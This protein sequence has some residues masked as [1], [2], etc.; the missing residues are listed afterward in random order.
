MKNLLRDFR[1]GRSGSLHGR[2]VL[3][4]VL[5]SCPGLNFH[6]AAAQPQAQ[7]PQNSS[8][9][10]EPAGEMAVKDEATTTK[11]AEAAK[12]RVNVR[13][14][15]ARVVVRD[16]KGN[17]VTNLHKEDF[18]LFDNGKPQVISNFDVEHL[19][20]SR[21][22]PTAAPTGTQPVTTTLAGPPALD[23][24][25]P[26]RYVAYLFDDLHLAFESV[27]RVREAAEHRIDRMNPEERIGI[28]STSGLT[29]ADFT[30][31]RTKLRDALKRLGPRPSKGGEI[32]KCPDINLYQADLIINKSDPE[33]EQTAVNEYVNCSAGM[34]TA[35]P[36]N[37]AMNARML[38]R[39]LAMQVL[40][41]EGQ[42]SRTAIGVLKDVVRR[43]STM[44][45]QRTL[46]LVSPGF[47]TPELQY[48]Y[49]EAIDRALRAQ[50]IINSLDARGLY[51]VTPFGDASQRGK[52]DLDVPGQPFT[53]SSHAALD[54]QKASAESEIMATLANATG[55]IFFHN[56]NDM[57]E[58]FRRVGEAPESYYLLGFT[59]TNLKPDGK[60]HNLKV[61][62]K[63]R[64]KYDL[65]VRRGYYAPN[66]ALSDEEEAKREI[67]DEVLSMEELH[68]L[69]VALHT[70]FFKASDDN[71]KL[72]VLARVDV[73]R[74]RY[75]QADDRNQNDL[76][77]VTAVFDRNGN[78]LQA[79]QKVVQMR[80]RSETLQGKLA[81]GITLTT[82]FDVKP[83]RYLVRVVARDTEQKLMSAENGSVEIP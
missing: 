39:G 44:P 12:F 24:T 49:N 82:H 66:H 33:A 9:G 3:L 4:F 2:C 22:Q 26:V 7:P 63:L 29:V 19:D 36:A 35:A 73:K 83:G 20:F 14:V 77:V 48:D 64:E 41:V 46:V 15:L 79:N 30:D 70:Q 59:P 72:T 50:V 56:N 69:P 52:P 13:L 58:G 68:D 34:T 42:D 57:D 54:I 10:Q 18:E 51:V 81:S 23:A 32:N 61:T 21:F 74:L 43:V 47:V 17:A 37:V 28:F 1:L 27:S 65:Q 45:G 71:A 5:L 11:M 60:Y 6:A 25:L 8:A 40:Q 31:D 76:T 38:V 78:F 80:W 75:K 16:S 62:L 53:P 67:E 55:G